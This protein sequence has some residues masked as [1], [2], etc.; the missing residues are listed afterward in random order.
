ML[1]LSS[2]C[3]KSVAQLSLGKSKKKVK[4]TIL[5]LENPEPKDRLVVSKAITIA[6]NSVESYYVQAKFRH[7]TAV[8]R[9]GS[10]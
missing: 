2:I 9:N 4:S 5:G 1:D 3:K 10:G 8:W 7:S 6:R